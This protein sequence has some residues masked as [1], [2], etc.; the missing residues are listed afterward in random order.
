[1]ES[2]KMNKQNKIEKDSSIQETDYWLLKWGAL[3][4]QAK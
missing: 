2:K 1:V 3:G 4:G